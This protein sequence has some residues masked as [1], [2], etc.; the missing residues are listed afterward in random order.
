MFMLN[1]RSVSHAAAVVCL[2]AVPGQAQSPGSA[3]NGD[4]L[5]FFERKIRPILVA[6]CY[7]CHSGDSK[8][9]GG[10]LRLDSRDGMLTGG[11]S[12][13]A[14]VPGEPEKSLLLQ[15][16]SYQSEL[17][18][19]PPNGKLP[20]AEIRLLT[21]WL[22]RGAMAPDAAAPAA[23]AKKTIDFEQGRKFWSF[24]PV[25]EHALPPVRDAAWPRERIDHFL[26]ARIEAAGLEP[27]PEADGRTLLR[28]AYFDVIGLSPSAA[29]VEAFVRSDSPGEYE[30][31]VERLLSS[32]HY[33]ER[34]GRFWLDL[35][36]YCDLPESWVRTEAQAWLYRDWVVQA[37]NDDLPYDEFV[38]RQLAADLLPDCGP[39]Q[40]AA[41]GL[42]GL[43]PNYWKELKLSQDVIKTVVAEEWEERIHT[44]GSA[45]LGLT[46]ACAR[47][48]DHKFD[49][50]STQDYYGLA[51]VLASTR[52]ADRSILP[53]EQAE[54]VEQARRQVQEWETEIKTVSAKKPQDDETKATIARLKQQVAEL[55]QTTPHYEA[56]LCYGV[57]EA[58]LHVRPDGEAR[59]KL[60]YEA[61]DPQ[62]VCV[63]IRG[64]PA[65]LGPEV[66]RRFLT[67]LSPGKPQPFTN[68]SGR[69]ELAE[70]ITRDAASLAARVIANRVWGYHFGRGLVDTASNFGAQGARPTHPE[71]LDD[72][73]ARFIESGWSLKWLHREILLSA[74]YRQ[75]SRRI[76]A[77]DKI[78]PENR[79]LWRMNRRRLDVEAWRDAMLAASG[80]L[81]RTVGGPPS[82][83]A[84]VGHHRRTLYGIV[85]RRDLN[86][87]LRLYD[88]PDP[89]THSARRD[90]TTTPLQQLFV[91]NSDLM[92]Q[93]A[94][95][96]VESTHGGN[97]EAR[98]RQLYQRLFQRLPTDHQRELAQRFLEQA[99]ANS[100]RDEAWLQYAQALLGSNEFMFVD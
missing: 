43:S 5:D 34:W 96:L 76:D 98:V 25:R 8:S 4:E 12:G 28:R 60:E 82:D 66:P 87:L 77:A 67:V 57:A 21:E 16:I 68:G 48:H 17:V 74:A 49:P 41:L 37:L 46:V 100:D 83:L 71:L 54:V 47:C 7:E 2:L 33:G 61:N 36:R 24:Q 70:A 44:L 6:R 63:Q 65:N 40:L 3:D 1:L 15:A 19:M 91:L 81:D 13:P 89:N 69:R 94:A 22:K 52:T 78:D 9:P 27:S 42:L 50:I 79:L 99:T 85:Q 72:L 31:A 30:R 23:S 11:D 80:A 84:D 29:E 18:Q 59:T 75:Q 35:V 26:L 45:L 90:Q 51:G 97:D 39:E 20:E 93:R 55:K 38:R 86:D 10:S 56:S 64:N 62:N 32:P 73:A 95:E 53:S 58:S 92:R 88:F 14:V